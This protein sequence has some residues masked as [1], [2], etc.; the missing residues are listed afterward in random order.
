MN[1]V[2]MALLLLVSV[3]DQ[4]L[5]VSKAWIKAP[6]AGETTAA[7]FLVVE[8][9]TAYDVYL[10][11]AASDAAERVQF[12]KVVD[13]K[14]EVVEY[15]IAP[16]YGSVEFTAEGVQLVLIDLKSPLEPGDKV[17]LTLTTDGGF[18]I[19]VEAEVKKN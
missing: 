8:N 13:K 2:L 5:K 7:A 15:V 18:D 6:A 10:M 14:A 11:S 1:L 3:A 12:R 17:P 16:A 4:Q 19:G 9:P